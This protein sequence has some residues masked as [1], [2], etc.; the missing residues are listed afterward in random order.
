LNVVGDNI[1]FYRRLKKHHNI[2]MLM[3]AC[4]NNE[5]Q[6]VI[7]TEHLEHGDL[8]KIMRGEEATNISLLNRLKVYLLSSQS[9]IQLQTNFVFFW[10]CCNGVSSCCW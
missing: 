4:L 6:L 9:L 8:K 5:G 1:S 2:V 3:G 10:C 7:I